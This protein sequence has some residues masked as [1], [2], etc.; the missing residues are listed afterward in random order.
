MIFIIRDRD[1]NK[2]AEVHAPDGSSVEAVP[3]SKP[4]GAIRHATTPAPVAE[5]GAPPPPGDY[6]LRFSHGASVEVPSLA[7]ALDPAGPLTVECWL[8]PGYYLAREPQQPGSWLANF[9]GQV[10]FLG[11]AGPPFRACIS[12]SG[13]F[14]F[15]IY[16]NETVTGDGLEGQPPMVLAENGQ[17]GGK[18]IYVSG[19]GSSAA[20]QRPIHLACVRSS[21][22]TQF[23]VAGKLHQ[24]RRIPPVTLA[25]AKQPFQIGGK[26]GNEDIY[27]YFHGVINEVRVSKTV[28]YDKD[29]TPPTRFEPDPETTAL[30]HFDEATGDVLHDASANKHD[31]KIIGATW[32]HVD[33][34]LISAVPTAKGPSL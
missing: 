26:D 16:T 18:Y 24:T 9:D 25:K 1:G 23:Y 17:T 7:E 22:Y 15:R 14:D 11:F 20:K 34:R 29:F 5:A 21:G 27:R 6:A 32:V 8:T 3:S 2:V 31:G 19:G 4:T 10:N 28:R 13:G 30:Y 33:G 12:N